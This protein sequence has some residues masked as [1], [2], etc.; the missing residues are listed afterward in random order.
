M[1]QFDSLKNELWVGTSKPNVLYRLAAA[2]GKILD[3]T[4]SKSPILDIKYHSIHGLVAAEVGILN[5]SDQIKGSLVAA[6]NVKKSGLHRPLHLLLADINNDKIQDFVVC[7]FGNNLGSLNW[8]DGKTFEEHTLLNQPGAR[9]V[10]QVDFNK[11]GKNDLVVL[12]TQG[13]EQLVLFEGNGKGDF[14]MKTLLEFPPYYGSSY[15]EL[16]DLDHDLDIVY[17][18]G[19]N[20]DLSI[21]QK[22][23]HGL[24]IFENQGATK[25]SETYFYPINGA[26]KVM[27]N[28]FDQDGDLDFAIISFFPYGLKE[29][30]LYFENV[31]KYEYKV[32]SK[33]NISTQK[34]LTMDIG[35]IDHDGDTDIILGAF[36]R[37]LMATPKAGPLVILSNT[38]K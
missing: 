15:F 4:V 1:T 37:D 22:P 19:D 12:F 24:R 9:V 35:D 17:T 38:L 16:H 36:N 3:S 34:W 7:N 33:A 2:T 26:S 27:A 18:C 28:D 13:K 25:F 8:Y 14:N 6:G 11:D 21:I 10:Y 29:G 5:P 20:A 23:F 30:F 32:R 31:K